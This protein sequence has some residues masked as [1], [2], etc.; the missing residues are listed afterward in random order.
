MWVV[1][2]ARG[3]KIKSRVRC[4]CKHQP[5]HHTVSVVDVYFLPGTEDVA[6][7]A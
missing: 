4:T 3:R 5:R 2:F 7:G 1:S 6:L